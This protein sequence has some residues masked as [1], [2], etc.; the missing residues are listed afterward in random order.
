MSPKM[1]GHGARG[2]L[3]CCAVMPRWRYAKICK[4][5]KSKVDTFRISKF[6][7]SLSSLSSLGSGERPKE[8][9]IFCSKKNGRFTEAEI[10]MTP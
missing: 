9:E 8:G 3:R 1:A 2:S 4:E 5:Q 10:P 6:S 7:S